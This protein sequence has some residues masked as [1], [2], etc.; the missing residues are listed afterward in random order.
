[1]FFNANIP[2]TPSG[3]RNRILLEISSAPAAPG[4]VSVYSL[5]PNKATLERGGGWW[6]DL[7]YIQIYFL[8]FIVSITVGY[9][10]IYCLVSL[11]LKLFKKCM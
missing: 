10:G 6:S 8:F 1:M 5:D 9:T 3:K 4:S 7:S 11:T 2:Q